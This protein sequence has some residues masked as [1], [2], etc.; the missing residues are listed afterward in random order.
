M[1]NVELYLKEAT[2]IYG[3]HPLAARLPEPASRLER[4]DFSH[5]FNAEHRSN[6][7]TDYSMGE[8]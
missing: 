2:V 6:L 1:R 4:L 5:L 3:F 7:S 8:R